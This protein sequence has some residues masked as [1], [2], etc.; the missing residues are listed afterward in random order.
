MVDSNRRKGGA[1][2]RSGEALPSVFKS[3]RRSHNSSFR[4]DI[5][6]MFGDD[7]VLYHRYKKY[8]DTL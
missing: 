5:D 8:I 6:V 1:H 3:P 2:D 7:V 4:E